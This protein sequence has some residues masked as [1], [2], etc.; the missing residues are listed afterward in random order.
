V[1]PDFGLPEQVR[2]DIV[3]VALIRKK[4]LEAPAKRGLGARSTGKP[5]VQNG[6]RQVFEPLVVQ[7]PANPAE[8]E[9]E[10]ANG[11]ACATGLFACRENSERQVLD[12]E[13]ASLCTLAPARKCLDFGWVAH[14]SFA[15]GNPRQE[16]S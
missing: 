7:E 6:L 16:R 15:F 8:I 13:F 2:F 1:E 9:Y 3:A 10:V 14:G 5:C 11:N 12:W 4:F